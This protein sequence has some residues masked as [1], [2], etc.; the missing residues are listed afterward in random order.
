MVLEHKLF[1]ISLAASWQFLNL[2]EPV[3]LE[4]ALKATSSQCAT[5]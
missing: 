3:L 1:F 2:D 4:R 5:G